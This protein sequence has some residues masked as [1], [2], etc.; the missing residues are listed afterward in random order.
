MGAEAVLQAGQLIFG[1]AGFVHSVIPI[2]TASKV[3]NAPSIQEVTDLPLT[4]LNS[5][6]L[7]S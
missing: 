3:Q 6:R 5:T 1:F 4:V 2:E 7:D